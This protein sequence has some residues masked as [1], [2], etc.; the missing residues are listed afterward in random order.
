ML[1]LTQDRHRMKRHV[2]YSRLIIQKAP[3]ESPWYR[4]VIIVI[5]ER[6]L[7]FVSVGVSTYSPVPT[8]TP[9]KTSVYFQLG[10]VISAQP[11]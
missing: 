9:T 5:H 10:A 8:S 4:S 2:Y 3:C 7:I 1:S 11:V 6:N